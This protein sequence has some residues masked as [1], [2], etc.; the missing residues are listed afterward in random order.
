MVGYGRT[1]PHAQWPGQANIAVQFVLNYE[2]GA[3][4]NVLD[5]DT[6]SETFLSEMIGA[7]AF[8]NR[9]MS[10]ESLYEYG[11]R[12]GVWRV[13]RAFEKRGLP[14]T[15]FAVAKA[16]ERNPEVVA[17]LAELG[18]EIACHGLRWLS[19]QQIDENV[20]REHMA[21]AVAILQGL[22]G[23]APL[24]WY[25][26]RDSPN[27]RSLVVE[28]GGFVYDSDSYADDLPYWEKVSRGSEVVDHLVVPYT[29]DTNDMRFASPGG[30]STGDEFYAHLR[31][32]FDVLYAEGENGRPKMLS[33]GLH[34][35]LVG[36]PAR[37]AALERFL[38]HVQSHDKVWVAKRIDIAEHW[39][40]VHPPS[41]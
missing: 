33:V 2:E 41:S 27:T 20:E 31:D 35:R 28:H 3:E 21:E 38:D 8:P 23:S 5:G 39:R 12:A 40:A 19:Y 18:H 30:F 29:L 6:K 14:L 1:P 17:A 36:R 25:T 26:G 10:M 9:H 7:Q 24:G 37:I 4:N 22:T 34:C 15:V 16:M 11:S 13:L 32:A